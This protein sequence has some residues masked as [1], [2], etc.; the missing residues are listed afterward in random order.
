[1]DVGQGNSPR[2]NRKE[3]AMTTTTSYGTWA[4]HGDGSLTIEDNIAASLGDYARDYDIPAIAADY[5][6]AIN[7]A[8]PDS[9]SINGDD[10]YGPAYDRDWTGYPTT[11][12]GDLDI[13]A[14]IETVDF[15]DI[16]ADHDKTA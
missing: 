12:D 8:L 3:P 2:P 15:W 1:M 13:K 16:A 10:F 4:N 6:R 11:A 7:S 9:V 14:I 5:R